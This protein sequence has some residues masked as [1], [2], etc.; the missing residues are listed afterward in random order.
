MCGPSSA[1]RIPHRPSTA[2]SV[3]LPRGLASLARLPATP[4]N[5]RMDSR[6]SPGEIFSEVV[7]EITTRIGC[8]VGCRFCPQSRLTR[9]YSSSG[10]GRRPE[11]LMTLDTFATCVDRLPAYVEV[12]FSGFAEPWLNPDCTEMLR[13]ALERDRQVRVHTTLQGVDLS[14]AAFLATVPQERIAWFSVHLPSRDERLERFRIDA[15]YLETLGMI[16]GTRQDVRLVYHGSGVDAR[17]EA[18]LA[19]LGIEL[20]SARRTHT[21]AGNVDLYGLHTLRRERAVGRLQGRIGCRRPGWRVLLPNGDVTLCCMDYGLQHVLG[22]LLVS[23]F[24]SVFWGAEMQRV[25]RG[26]EDENLDILCRTCEVW[27]YSW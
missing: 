4:D 8:G 10:D 11:H 24:E 17:V 26:R 3:P 13:Y 6:C 2:A 19:R 27:A 22:N 21:R 5:E 25:L 18:L 14:D 1:A 12:D 23:S 15:V 20:P 7:L 16:L 9:A